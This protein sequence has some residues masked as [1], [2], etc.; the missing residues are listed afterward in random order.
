MAL[1]LNNLSSKWKTESIAGKLD[2]NVFKSVFVDSPGE[3]Y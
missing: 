2:R 1:H 3:K